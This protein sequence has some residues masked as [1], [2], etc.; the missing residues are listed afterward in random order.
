MIGNLL[1]LQN[2]DGGWGKNLDWY[3]IPEGRTQAERRASIAV[4][5]RRPSTLDNR[6]TWSH[7]LY[8]MRAYDQVKQEEV[9][10]RFERGVRYVLNAQDRV[11]GGWRGSDVD[12]ITFNDDVMAGVLT[13]LREVVGGHGTLARNLAPRLRARAE[14]SFRAGIR[15][16]LEAQV[17]DLDGRRTAW[18][19]QHHHQ[20]LLPIA[21]RTFEPAALTALETVNVVRFL[22]TIEPTR[23]VREAV[24]GAVAWL[25]RVAVEGIR[26]DTVTAPPVRF[27]HRFS[28]EDRVA[29]KDPS[30]ETIWARFYELGTHRPIFSN[31]NGD[32]L[33]EFNLIP[34]ERREGYDWYGDWPNSL[35]QF[36]YPVWRARTES[37]PPGD[38]T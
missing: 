4:E 34:R 15:C 3:R 29:V 23:E 35:I 22:M 11:S 10:L 24:H 31:R 13:L 36:E 12:A 26:V 19:Q 8:L 17:R 33:S 27:P 6:T 7:L 20:T 28:V 25:R 14:E 9:A 30:A 18:G 2:P 16:V 38:G 1:L 21:G 37:A 5:G 32:I